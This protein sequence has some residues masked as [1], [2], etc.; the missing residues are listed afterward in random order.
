[1]AATINCDYRIPPAEGA[2]AVGLTGSSGVIQF[3]ID[4]SPPSVSILSLK[5][6]TINGGE[7]QLDFRVTDQSLSWVGYSLD[8]KGN[9]TIDMTTLVQHSL[10]P[11]IQTWSGNLTLAGLAN[12]SHD[13]KVY[14][15][16]IAGNEGL[17]KI[18]HFTLSQETKSQPEP[19]TIVVITVA[20]AV[21]VAIA[22]GLL[23]YF[24]KR[25][26]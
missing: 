14:T 22:A 7:V 19:T 17:S 23:F 2:F 4:T 25:K 12:G 18:I 1:V 21:A 20:S 3:L 15:R 8:D 26:Q 6:A 10:S 11:Y 9:V 16:D 24:K 13:L 5:N